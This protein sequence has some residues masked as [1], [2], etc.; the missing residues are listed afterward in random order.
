MPITI[1]I[2]NQYEPLLTSLR[3]LL[4][5]EE[6]IEVLATARDPV[7][8]VQLLRDL[9]PNILLL[10]TGL[11]DGSAIQTIHMVLKLFPALSLLA[12]GMDSG[13]VS[14]DRI[15]EAGALGYLPKDRIAEELATAVRTVASGR[16]YVSPA[17]E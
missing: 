8:L 2:A 12:L 10:D 4:Q 5:R 17:V 15:L 11:P 9:A 6:D 16:T 13:H 3:A 7:S 14:A 1:V